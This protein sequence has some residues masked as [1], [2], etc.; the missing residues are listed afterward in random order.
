MTASVDGLRGKVARLRE[1]LSKHGAARSWYLLLEEGEEIPAAI[2]AKMRDDD[3]VTVRRWP[4]GLFGDTW[5]VG[6]WTYGYMTA[7]GGS[8]II[9]P[10]GTLEKV[11]KSF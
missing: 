6:T 3:T 9:R 10:D 7:L 2:L 1:R 5:R 4:Q 8:S 11:S